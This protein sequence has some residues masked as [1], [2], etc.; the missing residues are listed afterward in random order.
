MGAIES[1]K[2]LFGKGRE[3]SEF[4][5]QI[6]KRIEPAQRYAESHGGKI[7]LVSATRD[8]V[9]T[10]RMK[11]ACA[12]CPIAPLTIKHG[13][14]NAIRQEF[15]EMTKLIVEGLIDSKIE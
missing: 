5:L 3:F 8:G 1:L 10:I 9:I 14:E 12:Y 4:E 11:G 6:L 13:V 15:P 2:S 7:E